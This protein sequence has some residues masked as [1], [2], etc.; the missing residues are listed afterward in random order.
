LVLNLYGCF[1]IP[2][3]KNQIKYFLISPT[4]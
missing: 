1:L 2:S 3:S 4:K